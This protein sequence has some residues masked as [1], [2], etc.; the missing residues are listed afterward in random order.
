MAMAR[1]A[2]AKKSSSSLI[3]K[4]RYGLVLLSLRDALIKVGIEITPF[5]WMKEGVPDDCKSHFGAEFDAYEFS[6][7]DA[8][9]IDLICALPERQFITEDHVK[10]T[11]AKGAKCYGA[12]YNGEIVG[13]TWFDLDECFTPFYKIAMK[14]NEAYLLDMYVL[15][16]YRGKNLA[17]FLRYKVYEVLQKMGVDSCYSITET[18][19]TPSFK[20]KQK[21]NAKII[22]LALFVRLRL[23][24]LGVRKKTGIL[25]RYK[26]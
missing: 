5:Y 9:D 17:P 15:N 12:K 23:G 4:F 24:F 7:F 26:D 8:A 14:D 22:F 16:A 25:R 19:N 13:F 11:F 21:L 1:E 20:F 10:T 18:F 2:I 6:F 3:N